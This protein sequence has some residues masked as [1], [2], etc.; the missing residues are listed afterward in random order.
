MSDYIQKLVEEILG[1][2]VNENEDL[3]L[4]GLDSLSVLKMVSYIEDHFD[5][6]IED[7]DLSIDNVCTVNAIIDMVG[8]YVD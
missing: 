6:E 3:F 8:N 2:K 1:N 5:I 7:E 4:A